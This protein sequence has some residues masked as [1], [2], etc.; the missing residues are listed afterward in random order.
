MPLFRCRR[1]QS[2]FH[3]EHKIEADT[4]QEAVREM[5]RLYPGS[6]PSEYV[7][8]RIRKPKPKPVR[9]NVWT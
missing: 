3:D 4:A 2:K 9:R 5:K 8:R 7:I 6:D 1:G